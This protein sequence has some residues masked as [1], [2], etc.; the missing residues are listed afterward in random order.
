MKERK[1]GLG[2]YQPAL[3]RRHFLKWAAVIGGVT[4]ASPGSFFEYIG[5]AEA[6]K[7]LTFDKAVW[8]ACTVNCGSRCILKGHVKDGVLQRITTDDTGDDSYGS[9]Q[10]RACLRGRSVRHRVYH[11]DRL[12]YPLKR[13][14]KRGEAKFERISW[15]LAFSEIAARMKD[16]IEKYGNE[17]LFINYATG[18]LG[19]IMSKSW[20][21]N[22]SPMARLMNTM[23]G[24][25]DQYGD[26]STGQ[27]ASALPP[28]FGD[29]WVGGNS[30]ADIAHS[31]LVLLFGDN[32]AACRM[33]GGGL[34]YDIIK[35]REKGRTK[36]ISIDPRFTDTSTVVG[37]EWIPIRPG[38]DAALIAGMAH[39]MIK[40]N[41]V[42]H[43]F[44]DRCTI[45]FD[46][47]HLPEGAPP[48]S[49]YKSYILGLGED[50][51]EK[52]PA[53]A[54][55][56]TG[57]PQGR[58]INLAREVAAAKPAYIV[59]GWGLQRHSN[60]EPASR[61]ICTLAA[62]TGN[63][64]VRGGNTGARESNVGFSFVGFPMLTNNVKAVISH[65]NWPDAIERGETMTATNAGVRGAEKLGANMKFLWNY[66]GNCLM[67]QHSDCNST[68]KLLEDDTKLET[69]VVV[70][71][72]MTSSA[73]F[74]DYVLP[75]TV[76][77]EERDF[78]DS[79]K[80]SKMQ[81][82]IFADQVVK[83]PGECK[84]IYDICAGIA[85][86]VGPDI[87]Q[88]FTE[89][90]SRDQWLAWLYKETRKK[91]P[92]LPLS[93]EDAFE[94]G[95]YKKAY[96]EKTPIPYERFREDPDAH[97]LKT[98]SGK[99]EIFCKDLYDKNT[100]WELPEGDRIPALPIYDT[101]WEG[102]TDP[103]SKKYPLQLIGHHYKQRTHSTY[104]N[105]DWTTQV[106][107]QSLWINPKDAETRGISHGDVVEIFNDR[108]RVH[109][110]AKMTQRIM[111][112]VLSLPQGAWF[113]PNINGVDTGGCTN[114]LTLYRP[115]PLAKSNPQHSNLVQV[116][117]V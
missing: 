113:A 106:A 98:P 89:G 30:F 29:G 37:D 71:N 99:I 34:V 32:P 5:V 83:P 90:R 17:S 91:Y 82:L 49:S 70:D 21:P 16:A 74:A 115:T 69:I 57:I 46:E 45:G 58:I 19:A 97:P 62:M 48:L 13:V 47:E 4:A 67:N 33:S 112:G 35:A 59:Q 95:I 116:K 52:T 104:G 65:Y 92:D 22:S 63:I 3:T 64:G 87:Y 117:K 84:N 43:D 88:A 109:I 26:Y 72:F 79:A 27:I 42:D 100:T 114:T 80:S 23:G 68:A 12:K 51:I 76:T 73:R 60:G 103:L 77:Q 55:Q 96:N 38:T 36:I 101:A 25:V 108:G 44:L 81:Y 41:L 110:P 31:K 28:M 14:G 85:K 18:T 6:Q 8:T 15:E 7:N 39:V 66:A 75:G 54:A 53:W 107:S 11:P 93:M 111:P 86:A 50:G 2:E 1:R 9:H 20:H 10:V 78:V 94:M 24:Y 40:E 56:L 102:H 105:I 61:A